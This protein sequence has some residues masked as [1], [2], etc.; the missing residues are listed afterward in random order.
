[1]YGSGLVV[2]SCGVMGPATVVDLYA[3]LVPLRVTLVS[4]WHEQKSSCMI[5]SEYWC[6]VKKD[7]VVV[8]TRD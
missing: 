1:M 6:M 5:R 4:P 3:S 8:E 7:C 2:L